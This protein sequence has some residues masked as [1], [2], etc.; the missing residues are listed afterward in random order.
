[1]ASP[2]TPSTGLGSG[3]DIG[4]IVTAL[5]NA[6][7]SAAQTQITNSQATNTLEAL[8]RGFAEKCADDLPDR[9]DPISTVRPLRSSPAS[10]QHR[11]PPSTLTA[12]TDNTAVAG[13]YN[14]TV[15]A[16][17]T[18][19][20]VASASFAGGASSAI[21]SGTLTISQNGTNYKV[22]I[23]ANATLQ[24]TRDAIN[25]TLSSNGISANIV[26]DSSGSSR[27][28]FGSTTT[29]V[30]SDL[31]VS[32]IAGLEVDG[33]QVMANPPSATSSGAITALAQNASLDDQRSD[34]Q[35]QEQY[36][37]RCRQWSDTES[38]L[39]RCSR[40]GCDLSGHRGYQHHGSAEFD[41]DVRERLQ[42]P[43]DDHRQ[44]QYPDDRLQW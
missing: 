40:R 34:G 39:G 21:P 11:G 35:Q 5:V 27:L 36:R 9:T 1:M 26:T 10:R 28:V 42:Q 15:N 44:S 4:S 30:G 41:P 18:G 37:H 23:P 17:A 12:T 2:I 7:K 24:S 8:R 31:S 14:I 3:L 38:A 19:S 16:L 43:D 13:S 25:S 33:T 6:D 32:G 29:G 22:T 20:Q